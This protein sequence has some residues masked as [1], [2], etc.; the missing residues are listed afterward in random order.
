MDLTPAGLRETTFRGALR[1]YNV[2]DVDEFV[3]RVA[4]GVGEL[5]E[6]VRLASQRAAAAERRAK[7]VVSSERAVKG[8]LVEAQRRAEAVVAEARQRAARIEAEARQGAA[9]LR[10]EAEAERVTS[11]SQLDTVLA[12]ATERIDAD[13][14]A[15]VERLHGVRQALQVDVAVLT[16]WMSDRRGSL[17]QVLVDTLAAIDRSSPAVD[18]PPVS[19]V[20]PAVRLGGEAIAVEVSPAE[21]GPPPPPASAGGGVNEPSRGDAADPSAAELLVEL[22]KAA[23]EGDDSP[24][25]QGDQGRTP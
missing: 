25:R 19:D 21:A 24:L 12:Q 18:P 10:A 8:T 5:L 15:E 20:D 13:L 7:E 2:D 22:R 1:G 11:R 17:R 14:R 4:D 3:E 23:T 6:Q 9:Q 16:S